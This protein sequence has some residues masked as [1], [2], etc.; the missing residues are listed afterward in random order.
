M[1]EEKYL[2]NKVDFHFSAFKTQK[3]VN[4]GWK[5]KVCYPDVYLLWETY[6]SGV[7]EEPVFSILGEKGKKQNLGKG[8]DFQ[9]NPHLITHLIIS[10]AFLQPLFWFWFL[11]FFICSNPFSLW[12]EFLFIFWFHTQLLA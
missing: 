6:C 4:L 10:L 7:I 2:L 5:D 9:I 3:Y 11:V 12:L 1:C 8:T